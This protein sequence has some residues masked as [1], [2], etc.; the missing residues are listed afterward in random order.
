MATAAAEDCLSLCDSL[1]SEK[2]LTK[3]CYCSVSLLAAGGLVGEAEGCGRAAGFTATDELVGSLGK[4]MLRF[5][6]SL[7]DW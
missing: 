3:A 1:S 7:S 6:A 5:G 2:R 4:R